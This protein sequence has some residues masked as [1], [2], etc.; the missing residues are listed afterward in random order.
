MLRRRAL[1][2]FQCGE[3]AGPPGHEA[4]LT[5]EPHEGVADPVA[6][7]G[8]GTQDDLKLQRSWYINGRHYSLT[9]EAWLRRM[10]AQRA[11]IMP[12]MQ[13]GPGCSVRAE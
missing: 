4:A 13:V 11:Q 2:A 7:P 1:L 8:G 5:G 10:D 3:R 9:L 12:I 6:D